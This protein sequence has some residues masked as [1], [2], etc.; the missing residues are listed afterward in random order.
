MAKEILVTPEELRRQAKQIRMLENAD[1]NVMWNLTRLVQTLT[2]AWNSPSQVAFVNKYMSMQP[3]VESFH[4]AIEELALL[5]ERHADR[6]E[7]VDQDMA[8]KINK[9]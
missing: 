9:L 3:A 1:K 2:V 5:M 6:M 8:N 4:Q 7:K